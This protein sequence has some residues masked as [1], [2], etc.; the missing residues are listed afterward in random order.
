[1]VA[2]WE[3]SRMETPHSEAPE[4]YETA[5]A[6]CAPVYPPLPGGTRARGSGGS[7]RESSGDHGGASRS[8]GRVPGALAGAARGS[9]R[10]APGSSGISH[11][12]RGGG[13]SPRRADAGSPTLV[14]LAVTG[15][16]LPMA[17]AGNGYRHLVPTIG[18][19]CRC[20][21][22]QCPKSKSSPDVD[23]CSTPAR[24]PP[25]TRSH[26][27]ARPR[28]RPAPARAPELSARLGISRGETERA[29]ATAGEA[30]RRPL[31]DA[32]V[33]RRAGLRGGRR[34]LPGLGGPRLGLG[35]LRRG[36]RHRVDQSLGPAARGLGRGGGGG[37][38]GK[39]EESGRGATA[40]FPRLKKCDSA[41]PW[42][43]WLHCVGLHCV[44]EIPLEILGFAMME[45]D[46]KVRQRRPGPI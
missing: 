41:G 22:T 44:G 42:S 45:T 14:D 9:A 40:D 19:R 36:L 8:P 15:S 37:Q 6:Q 33:C 1:M 39:G 34:L 29:G 3:K 20:F 46:S 4:G 16:W 11:P 32:Y 12:G 13:V 30:A 26:H 38:V 43:K 2:L 18:L 10:A 27:L 31:P 7:R 21:G 25:Q 5:Q 28:F 35:A 17:V 24:T 23:E